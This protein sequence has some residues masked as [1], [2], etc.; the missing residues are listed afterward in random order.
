MECTSQE[1]EAAG[2]ALDA[3]LRVRTILC[4]EQ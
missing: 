1:C 4:G 2:R 3:M